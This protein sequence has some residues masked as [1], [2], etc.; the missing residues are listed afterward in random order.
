[1]CLCVHVD[2]WCFPIASSLE[3]PAT[4]TYSDPLNY[5]SNWKCLFSQI[6]CQIINLTVKSSGDQD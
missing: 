6:T 1:M 4:A 2:M 3:G 5:R